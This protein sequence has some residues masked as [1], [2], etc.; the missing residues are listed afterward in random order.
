[1]L[2]QFHLTAKDVDHHASDEVEEDIVEESD[3]ENG[4]EFTS[5]HPYSIMHIK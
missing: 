3:V 4:K 5:S 1:M 2:I